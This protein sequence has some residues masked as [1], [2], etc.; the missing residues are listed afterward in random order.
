MTEPRRLPTRPIEQVRERAVQA[1]GEHF[2]RDNLTIE[3]LETR[4]ERVYAASTSQE[5]EAL[6]EG[7]PTL[8]AGAPL[9]ETAD[10]RARPPRVRERFV[11]IMSGFIRRGLWVVPRRIR[12]IAVMGGIDLDLREA[13]LSPGVTEIHAFV[14]MGGLVIRVPPGVRLETSGIAIMG[15][16]DDRVDLPDGAPPDAP[17]VRVTG[18]AI[19]GGVDA[20]VLAVGASED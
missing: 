2:A 3:E 1:L 4:M 20:K 5:V 9:P 14:F 10:A 16:F 18:V 6:L 13:Q 19:M 15:G 7:L 12:A 11:A 8:T 17:V